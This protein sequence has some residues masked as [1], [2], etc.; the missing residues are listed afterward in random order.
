MQQARRHTRSVVL[1]L[2]ALGCWPLA[3]R[4]QPAAAPAQATSQPAAAGSAPD[5]GVPVVEAAA[6]AQ[7]APAAAPID[8][9][10][11]ASP[12]AGVIQ[13]PPPAGA[14]EAAEPAQPSQPEGFAEPAFGAG[15][16][17]EIIEDPELRGVA[18]LPS[19]QSAPP[20][21][22]NG[23]VR[24]VLHSRFGVA[25]AWD[26]RRKDVIESTNI[27]LLEAHV[28]RSET[29]RFEVGARAR[30]L[31]A[32]RQ[33]GT[34]DANPERY[35]LDVAPTALF[36]DLTLAAGLHLRL[37]YQGVR[38]GRFDVLNPSD[39][40]SSYDLRS[41][42]VTMPDASEIAQPAARLDW[43]VGSWLSL[44]LIALP[45]F[46]PHLVRAFE[47]NYALSPTTQAQLDESYTAI[48]GNTDAE[49]L[50]HNT[51]TRSGQA[52]LSESA[53]S[54]FT[55][56][57]SF[58]RPQGALRMTAHGPAGE[59]GLTAGSALEHLPVLVFSQTFL[60]ALYGGTPAPTLQDLLADKHPVSVDYAR[61]ELLSLDG[62]TA[63][64]PLQLGAELAYMFDRALLAV[65]SNAV[66]AA[67]NEPATVAEQRDL[68]HAG[69]RL[70]YLQGQTL[71][72]ALEASIEGTPSGP[73]DAQ[74]SFAFMTADR[75]MLSSV[76]FASYAPGDLGLTLEL[77]SGLLNG[78]TYFV[79]P[80]VQQRLFQG[81]FVE[82]GAWLIGGKKH[83][84]GD[85]R[86]TLASLYSATN[87]VFVGLRW[88]P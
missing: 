43:D 34:L 5:A 42:P 40:L 41:G 57:P 51:L 19:L 4:A 88:L 12:D 15:G 67:R 52:V 54:A 86:V 21:E 29:L 78:P 3:T 27:A 53:F 76:A 55:P 35:E 83:P 9:A 79:A 30:Y 46:Q 58:T 49:A 32:R 6:D 84:T 16:G 7:E 23:D 2:A 24:V 68:L 18:K 33:H 60:N 81:F 75:L 47:G 63:L 20:A 48:F 64:G 66:A 11:A 82:A 73:T 36:G 69:L 71:V 85:P 13:A 65:E 25:T 59:L 62:A 74:R 38:L 45:F 31:F 22:P 56:D 44:K 50:L 70:E 77:G 8:A 10:Q 17:D 39:I 28:R 80:R 26:E 61:F 87:Q 72:L 14:A 1:G 37:G